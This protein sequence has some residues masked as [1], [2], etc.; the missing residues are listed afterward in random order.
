[1]SFINI[2]LIDACVYYP[3]SENRLF[4]STILVLQ[5]HLT[6]RA[7]TSVPRRHLPRHMHRL[8]HRLTPSRAIVSLSFHGV[9]LLTE[10]IPGPI[11]A[12]IEGFKQ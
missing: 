8:P 12:N 5:C 7:Y 6:Q 1:M 10:A 4:G 3:I 9:D 2:N 11:A